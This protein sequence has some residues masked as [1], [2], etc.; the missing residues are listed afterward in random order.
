MRRYTKAKIEKAIKV[1]LEAM[2]EEFDNLTTEY[3][4]NRMDD[5]LRDMLDEVYKFSEFSLMGDNDNLMLTAFYYFFEYLNI[6]DRYYDLEGASDILDKYFDEE[7]IEY[8]YDTFREA[9]HEYERRIPAEVADK[10]AAMATEKF[11]ID[12]DWI[13]TDYLNNTLV[14]FELTADRDEV[15]ELYENDEYDDDDDDDEDYYKGPRTP[16]DFRDF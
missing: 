14:A 10:L 15:E 7:T 16:Y 1:A 2:W 5:D 6:K 11:G 4:E 12:V 13:G 3:A 9:A 8:I